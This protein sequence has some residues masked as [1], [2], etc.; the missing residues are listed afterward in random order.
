VRG[1]SGIKLEGE[2]NGRKFKFNVPVGAHSGW[3]L[4]GRRRITATPIVERPPSTPAHP[5]AT[6]QNARVANT[7]DPLPRDDFKLS[8]REHTRQSEGFI[9]QTAKER[10]VKFLRC[11]Y[12]LRNLASI[13]IYNLI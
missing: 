13:I 7:T 5:R 11:E 8:W 12:H 3:E 4:K 2:A 10:A 9:V 1:N 6:C